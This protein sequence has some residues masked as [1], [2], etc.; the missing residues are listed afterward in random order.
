MIFGPTALEDAAG[1]VLAHS[2]RAG[3]KRLK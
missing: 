1:A 2:M 3:V